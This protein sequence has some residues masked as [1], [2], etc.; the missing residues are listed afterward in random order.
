MHSDKPILGES[1]EG[2]ESAHGTVTM[3]TG[4]SGSDCPVCG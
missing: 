2:A 3:E 4:N 1:G